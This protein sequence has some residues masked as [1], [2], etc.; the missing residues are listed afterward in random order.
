CGFYEKE[1][2]IFP[3]T[4]DPNATENGTHWQRGL[5][6]APPSA[7][8]RQPFPFHGHYA[9]AFVS[10]WMLLPGGAEQRRVDTGF[11][12]SDHAGYDEIHA[13]IA[14]CEAERVG[15][16]HGYIDGLVAELQAAGRDAFSFRS[17]RC[18]PTPKL[19]ASP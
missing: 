2:V 4:F 7:R 5:Y 17:P 13:T 8:W 14:A 12:L 3:P 10:G 6:I 15:V 11:A 16:M 9:T 18:G 19:Q 1:G